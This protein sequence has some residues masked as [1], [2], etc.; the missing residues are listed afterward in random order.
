MKLFG[1]C[2]ILSFL[3]LAAAVAFQFLEL[4]GLFGI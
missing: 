2:M 4:R 3:G 1:I